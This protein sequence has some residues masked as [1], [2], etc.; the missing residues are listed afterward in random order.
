MAEWSQ[1]ITFTYDDEHLPLTDDGVPTLYK[2][3]VQKFVRRLKK[4]LGYGRLRYFFVGEYGDLLKRPH[5]HALFFFQRASDYK[6][7]TFELII[8]EWN[9]GG[10]FFGSLTPAS[11]HYCTKY[12]L[13]DTTVPD[14]AI[15][16]GRP[17]CSSKPAIGASW[18][19]N[20]DNYNYVLNRA[21]LEQP[22]WTEVNGIKYCI[23]RQIRDRVYKKD[24]NKRLSEEYK[25]EFAVMRDAYRY[26]L[27]QFGYDEY[28]WLEYATDDAIFREQERL[29]HKTKNI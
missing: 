3:D 29:R 8:R 16:F 15:E 2:D 21:Q 24:W 5:Y 17:V 26:R 23:P 12:C 19:E 28:S 14:G 4:A 27:S 18:L 7:K 6:L 9:K 11:V 22:A 1:F 10:V 13:K 25:S 20:E